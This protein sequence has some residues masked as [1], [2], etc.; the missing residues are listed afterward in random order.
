VSAVLKTIE[1]VSSFLRPEFSPGTYPYVC[2][3][4]G[5]FAYSFCVTHTP[6]V[7]DELLGNMVTCKT[8][9]STMTA[10]LWR[11][12]LRRRCVRGGSS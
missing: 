11:K 6:C 3:M 12:G 10:Q 2:V 1:E 8:L 4:A 5:R 9:N 7:R